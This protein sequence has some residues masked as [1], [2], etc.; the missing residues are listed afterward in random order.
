[1][2]LKGFFYLGYNN[3][4]NIFKPFQNN[5]KTLIHKKDNLIEV[6]LGREQKLNLLPRKHTP[7]DIAIENN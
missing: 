5:K 4:R 6:W 3:I 1:M 2:K 7:S